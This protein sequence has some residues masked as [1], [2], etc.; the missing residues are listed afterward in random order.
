MSTSVPDNIL[1]ALPAELPLFPLNGVLLLPRGTLPLNVF[2]PRYLAMVDAALAGARMIGIIQPAADGTIGLSAPDGTNLYRTGCAGRITGFQETEDGRYLL[3]L[4]GICRFDAAEELELRD[5]Y[6]RIRPDFSPYMEDLAPPDKISI[7]RER[8]LNGLKGYFE[9]QNIAADWD[10][11]V[12]TPDDRLVTTLSMVCPFDS[13]EK[14]VLLEAAG[15]AQRCKLLIG[16][17][18]STLRADNGNTSLN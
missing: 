16:F 1:G 18:E 14:Q 8:L 6:R 15:D 11:L 12:K 3:E 9:A 7:E 5:G 13:A 17:I 4:R 10:A 2:E